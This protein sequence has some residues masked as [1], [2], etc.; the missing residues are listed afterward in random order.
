M[1]D[2]C[3]PP[4]TNNNY[5]LSAINTYKPRPI[6]DIRYQNGKIYKLMYSNECI[7]IGC[8]YLEL[9]ERLM[10]HIYASKSGRGKTKLNEFMRKIDPTEVDIELIESFPCE[11]RGQLE[12]REQQIIYEHRH[13]ISCLNKMHFNYISKEE[14]LWNSYLKMAGPLIRRFCDT[15]KLSRVG[16]FGYV[17]GDGIRPISRPRAPNFNYNMIHDEFHRLM[18]ETKLPPNDLWDKLIRLNQQMSTRDRKKLTPKII[19]KCE[20]SGLW[21][22]A[23]SRRLNAIELV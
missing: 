3:V 7:Y 5:V 4:D 23:W 20:R 2:A 8:T 6:Y 1:P 13:V 18:E 14:E 16:F 19:E 11:S 17:L 12:W 21:L 9:Y 15:Y 22:F 10:Q